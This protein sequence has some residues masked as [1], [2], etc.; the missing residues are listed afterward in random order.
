VGETDIYKTLTGGRNITELGTLSD[1]IS[2]IRRNSMARV[3]ILI[4]LVFLITYGG[5]AVA[6]LVMGT[7]S[8]I[9]VV[10]S[11]SMVPTLNVGDIVIVRGIDPQTITVGTV[12]IFKSPSGSI[13]IIHRV[14]GITKVG[15]KLYFQTKGDHNPAPDPWSPGVPEDNVK[16]VLV[17]KIPYVGYVT[18][19]LQGPVGVALIAFL[20]FLMI[21]FE[22]YDS[23][24]NTSRRTG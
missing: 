4:G 21:I 13:D 12:I 10:P 11:T 18:L 6:R 3:I 17:A 15:D 19:A 1:L 20:I 7:E 22:Y 8:P 9:M 16:G 2:S 14:I 24:K 23:R 5:M